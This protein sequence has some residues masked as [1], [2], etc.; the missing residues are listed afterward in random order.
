MRKDNESEGSSVD[1]LTL[2]SLAL[3]SNSSNHSDCDVQTRS[4]S[5]HSLE[6][7]IYDGLR[8]WRAACFVTVER[9]TTMDARFQQCAA[10]DALAG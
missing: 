7:A 6:S 2:A 8:I 1:I 10:Y 9:H 4:I 5:K 3:T